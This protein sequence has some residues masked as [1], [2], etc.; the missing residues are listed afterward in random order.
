MSASVS[1][2]AMPPMTGVLALAAAV[3]LERRLDVVR[4]L[5]GE[6]RVLRQDADAVVAVAG[7]AGLRRLGRRAD[8]LAGG[9]QLL[10]RRGRPRCPACPARTSS[11]RASAWWRAHAPGSRRPSAPRRGTPCA[12]H[13]ASARCRPGRRSCSSGCHGSH[14]RCR[15]AWRHARRRRPKPAPARRGPRWSGSGRA[16]PISKV[17]A[18]SMR[19]SGLSP[20]AEGPAC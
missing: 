13:P 7:D 3:G 14:G 18:D 12:G 20:K 17:I 11:R 2:A 16:R 10:R 8:G 5:A 6:V 9:L 4:V 1:G 15:Q 19:D